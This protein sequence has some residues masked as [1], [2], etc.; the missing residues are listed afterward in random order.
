M[1]RFKQEKTLSAFLIA[2]RVHQ[3]L[4]I[5]VYFLELI[6]LFKIF[7]NILKVMR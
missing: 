7:S 1:E 6:P 5:E 2:K 4:L 3:Y